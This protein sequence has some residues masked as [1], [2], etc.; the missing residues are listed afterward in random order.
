LARTNE[1]RSIEAEI[2]RELLKNPEA[3]RMLREQVELASIAS[4]QKSPQD[5]IRERVLATLDEL[6]GMTV[7]DQSIIYTGD[8]VMLPSNFEGNLNGAIDYLIEVRDNEEQTYDFT[9][10]FNY[11]PW[12]GAA[13][14]SRAMQ[15]VFGTSGI[16]KTIHTFFG[17]HPP[18]LRSI[19]VSH[20]EN[21]Q[22]PWGQIKFG[23]LDATFALGAT[24]SEEFG[25]I[26]QISVE[27]PRKHRRRIE[28][29]LTVVEQELKEHS[30]YRGRMIN[31]SEEMPG[32]LNPYAVSRDKVVYS[33]EVLTQ[34]QANVWTVME[35][36]E[37]FRSVNMPLKRAVLLE[38]PYGS[39][40]SLAGL[41]TA[42]C[43][44]ENGWTFILV[45][46][47]DDP[48]VALKTAALY[49]PAVVWVEDL[50]VLVANKSREEITGLLDALDSVS[51]KGK[52]VIAGYTTNFPDIMDKGVLRP[53]RLDA[54]IHVGQL[55]AVGHE[56]LIKATIPS[57][58][59]DPLVNYEEVVEALEGYL[60]AFTVEAAQRAFRYAVARSGGQPESITTT[61]LVNAAKGLRPQFDMASGAGEA[62]HGKATIDSLVTGKV[63]DVVRRTSLDGDPFTVRP[64]PNG[65]VATR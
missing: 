27:A 26:F 4:K 33:Q 16:G 5:E 53:G 21:Q 11:R 58:I 3:Q 41:L 22:V 52:E 23:Q 44:V 46:S 9:R 49:A 35:N 12:D 2:T 29:F 63:E 55:D 32:F 60:P 19:P 54:V 48:Y 36:A 17:S 30:I 28:G 45:R 56:M 34:L 61:D 13:A 57:A 47:G 62:K 64:A 10:E 59:L 6:G 1:K 40:K 18:Q 50:D 14:F 15:R 65:T 38:G 42:Q 8:K 7:T 37:Y 39:G 20:N 51:T 25:V 43:A 31:A 24:G